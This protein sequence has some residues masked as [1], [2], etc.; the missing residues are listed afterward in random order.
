M[1]LLREV[2]IPEIQDAVSKIKMA[3]FAV[4]EQYYAAIVTR[5]DIKEH[6]T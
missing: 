6:K 2:Q 3:V 5:T 1:S 4:L